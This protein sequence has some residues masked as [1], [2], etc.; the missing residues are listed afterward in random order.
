MRKVFI[1][2]TIFLLLFIPTAYSGFWYFSACKTKNLLAETILYVNDEKFDISY[3]F[4]GF[5]SSINFRVTNPKFSN[6]QLTISSEAL[7]I[8]NRLL[9]KSIYIYVPSNKINITVHGNGTKN[10]KCYTNNN[11][12]FVVKLNDLPS[13]LRFDRNS[14]M[15]DYINTLR[16]EDYGLKCD[17][18]P[19]SESQQGI[20]TEVNGKSN[21]I[22][23]YLDKELSGNAKLEFD[24][25]TYR[26]KNTANPE[27]YLSVDTKFD[28]E[29]VNHI[30]ASRINFNIE[31]FLVQS[32]NFSL[33]ADGGINNYN[34]VT[35]SFKDKIDVVI[36]NYQK[37]ISFVT[38][39]KNHSKA[40]DALE[41]LISSLSEKTTDD[42]IQFSIKY[43]D[44]VG[45][46][47]IGK[48]SATD[49]MNQLSQITELTENESSS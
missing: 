8:K 15:I 20:V 42:S 25:Y 23:F 7:V 3:D 48:L 21:Y 43:N 27:S 33:T 35:S 17:V 18:S 24:F 16:Y 32:N 45:S 49:F 12:H 30:S 1:Y 34:L 4:S 11:N 39:E 19:D 26:Y 2:I 6:E 38:G 46:S 36:S 29:F 41:K 5:P 28:C 9:D 13:S 40:S 14:T 10:I 31:K 47:F 44:D 22:Q 37:L